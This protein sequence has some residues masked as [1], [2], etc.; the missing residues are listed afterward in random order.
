MNTLTLSQIDTAVDAAFQ[1]ALA[2][3]QAHAADATQ[4]A[5]QKVAPQ[6]IGDSCTLRT[7]IYTGSHGSGFAVATQLKIGKRTI[8]HIRQYGP[9]TASERDWDHKAILDAL[10][11]DYNTQVAKG[12]TVNGITLAAQKDDLDKFTQLIALLREA[13][14]LQPDEAAK[15]AFR[16]SNTN[17][18]DI[19]NA[20]HEVT[21]TEARQ[22]IVQY[23]QM[24]AV[25]WTNYANQRAALSA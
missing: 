13:E 12:I 9:E 18:T 25:L 8:T 4:P 17:I 19:Q 20:V 23:G 21:V 16:A 5:L 11:A 1:T 2:S 14:E 24:V 7:D 15:A 3:S 6:I 22:L 10:E